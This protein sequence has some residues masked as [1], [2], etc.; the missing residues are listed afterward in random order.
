MTTILPLDRM[1]TE[2]KLR[3]LEELWAD[4]SRSPESVPV[5]EWHRE[6][7][8]AREQ[9]VEEGAA[10][11]NEWSAVKKRIRDRVR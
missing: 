10:S 8:S 11:F 3:A 1:S 6:V 5:P 4:L 2:E 9:R 7:L